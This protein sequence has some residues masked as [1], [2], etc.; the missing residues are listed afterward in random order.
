MLAHWLTTPVIERQRAPAEDGPDRERALSL[1]DVRDRQDLPEQQ[2][3]IGRQIGHGRFA[4]TTALYLALATATIGVLGPKAATDVPLAGLLAHVIGT[5][6]PTAAAVAAIVL[7]V[8]T[9][10]AYINGAIVMT[11][12]LIRPRPDRPGPP[13]PKRLLLSAIA[14]TGVVLL[15]AYGLHL[16]GTAALVAAPTTLFLTVYLGA[17]TAAIRILSGPTRLAAIPGALAVLTMLTFC[18]WALIIPA[19]IALATARSTRTR[20]TRSTPSPK[21]SPSPAPDPCP[22]QSELVVSR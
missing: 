10:N 21:P 3:L 20:P 22:A 2:L 1:D 12:E 8:G 15:T 14:V 9:T 4:V 16:V 7:T 6:G 11:G 19:A 17:M 5:A 18:S 13:A